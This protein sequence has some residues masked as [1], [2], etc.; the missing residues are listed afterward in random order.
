[1]RDNHQLLEHSY[2]WFDHL[3][4]FF[5]I[6]ILP[7]LSFRSGVS[8]EDMT[9]QLPPKKHLFYTNGLALVIGAM[10]VITAWNASD[11]SW[12]AMGVGP[13]VWNPQVMWLT[14]AIAVVYLA[15]LLYGMLSPRTTWEEMQ[16]LQHFIPVNWSEYRH[17][18][19]LALA[20]G[21]CEEIIFRGFLITYL[22]EQT[23]ASLPIV[24]L[25]AVFLP[26][27]VF[28]LS[29]LYQGWFSVL[30]IFLVALLLGWIFVASQSLILPIII[31]CAI[32]LIS[33]IAG[34]ITF[35]KYRDGFRND[36]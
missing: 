15:D 20:A 13:M 30:K 26:A 5:L 23:F 16:G 24:T 11:R 36:G 27:A 33:G 22:K 12:Q 4:A 1:M 14:V 18:V 3:I 31:H 25:L 17:Y 35:R 2:T 34:M 21:I 9:D 10:L 32:D 19:F 28:S 8:N 6:F 7:A 29:H